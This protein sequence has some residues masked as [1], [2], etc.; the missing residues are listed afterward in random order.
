MMYDDDSD[1]GIDHYVDDK[2]SDECGD[3]DMME[4]WW[5]CLVIQHI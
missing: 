3:E 1:D 2:G 4:W 5:C